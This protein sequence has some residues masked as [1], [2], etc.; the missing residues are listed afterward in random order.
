MLQGTLKYKQIEF[1][2][3]I[4]ENNLRLNPKSGY[5]DQFAKEFRTVFK[6]GAYTDKENYLEGNY[7]VGQRLEN[8]QNIVII[9]SSKRISSSIFNDYL[10]IEIQYIIYLNSQEPISRMSIYCNELNV[11]YDTRR[12]IEK[13]EFNTNGEVEVKLKSFNDTETDKFKFKIR[14]KEIKCS[15]NISKTL[16]G[17]TT[18]YPVRIRSSIAL[19]FEPIQDYSILSD[20]YNIIKRFIQYLC[21]RRNIK[22]EEVN[23]CTA[24]ENG[25]YRRI[26]TL[27]T[28]NDDIIKEEN[29]ILEN[30]FISYDYIKGYEDNILQSIADNNLYMRHI[31]LSYKEGKRVNEATFIMTTAAF[32]WEFKKMYKDG[33]PHSNKTNEAKEKAKSKIENLIRISKGKEKKIYKNLLKFITLEGFSENLEYTCNNLNEIIRPFGDRLYG[34][35]NEKLDYKKMGERLA[36][37]RTHFA[38]GDLDKEFIGLAL[39]DLIFLEEIVY[40]MQLKKCGISNENIKRSLNKLFNAGIV[41]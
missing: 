31:P 15:L 2:F 26:G 41:L 28:I 22:I 11:I 25:K 1:E 7:L 6:E 9:P 29:K 4:E 17:K 14:N 40:A 33:I 38:H 32:E 37:Q 18:E 13:S 5:E 24:T 34:L 10:Y 39:L 23:I 16:Y 8:Y 3:L 12:A 36:K 35:N 27:E 30:R 19:E 20:L 21:Y